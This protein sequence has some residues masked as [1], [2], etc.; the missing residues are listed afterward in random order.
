[1]QN[2]VEFQADFPTKDCKSK[3]L[4]KNAEQTCRRIKS[5]PIPF[6]PE[7]ALWIQRSLV[8]RS[9]LQYHLGFI[10]NQG[11]PKRKARWCRTQNCLAIPIPE[12][13]LG[14][15]A[16][17][18]H[19]NFYRNHGKYY[20]TKYLYKCLADAQDGQQGSRRERFW[21]S[22]NV[23]KKEVSGVV[24]TMPSERREAGQW[25]T[26]LWMIPTRKGG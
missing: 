6:S 12:I 11:N 8:Y 16:A 15:K 24:S 7:A 20:K 9:L 26:F 22:F 25:D 4:M 1:L 3:E 10:W 19:C 21:Q 14:L 18:K 23:K 2:S 17:T 5:G 13:C